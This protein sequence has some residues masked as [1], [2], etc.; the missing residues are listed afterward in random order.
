MCQSNWHTH[1]AV[2]YTSC[3]VD[4]LSWIRRIYGGAHGRDDVDG[5]ANNHGDVGLDT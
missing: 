4:K 1:G 5:I 2:Q 3:I